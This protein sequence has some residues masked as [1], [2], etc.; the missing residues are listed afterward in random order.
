MLA[1]I[2]TSK[3]I[4]KSKYTPEVWALVDYDS[5][6]F[7]SF[8]LDV[9]KDGVILDTI[10]LVPSLERTF[11]L[12]GRQ[13]DVCHIELAHA[14]ISRVHAVLQYNKDRELM[15]QDLNSAQG[16]KLNKECISPSKWVRVRPGD[17][18][19]FG[20][21]TRTFI[22]NGPEEQ[23]LAEYDS[24][25]LRAY[26]ESMSK[27]REEAARN[28]EVTWGIQFDDEDQNS[29]D[30]TQ[31][32][33]GDEGLALQHTT[34]SVH[35]NVSDTNHMSA[36]DRAQM[37]ALNVKQMKVAR[38]EADVDRLKSKQRSG[39]F[40]EGQSVALERAEAALEQAQNQCLK[41]EASLQRRADARNG[42]ESSTKTSGNT[43]THERDEESVYDMSYEAADVATNFRLRQKLQRLQHLPRSASSISSH[44]NT[45]NTRGAAQAMTFEELQTAVTTLQAE[46]M[47]CE[48]QL[49][50]TL[51][52]SHSSSNAGDSVEQAYHEAQRR[53]AQSEMRIVQAR[54]IYIQTQLQYMYPMLEAARPALLSPLSPAAANMNVKPTFLPPSPSRPAVVDEVVSLKRAKRQ[55]D[56]CQESTDIFVPPQKRMN[57]EVVDKVGT[58]GLESRPF[59]GINADVP[60]KPN[61][62]K[63]PYPL[64]PPKIQHT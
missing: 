23:A 41:L 54:I 32:G 3:S 24:E 51:K 37:E 36:R 61:K 7:E 20:E 16:T 28:E 12:L 29:V 52:L 25:N 53:E 17:Q 13:T 43:A 44:P 45:G 10:S 19:R 26:R 46:Q 38:L 5:N 18:I 56:G 63:A 6:S 40:T 4:S 33:E 2:G 22:V 8:S 58:D 11:F 62:N 48:Q 55:S 27:K 50:R 60:P 15:L 1:P 64:P 35:S 42:V 39:D 47:Q 30:G 57:I 21:S 31:I 9:L 49:E 14:S 59:A 34:S